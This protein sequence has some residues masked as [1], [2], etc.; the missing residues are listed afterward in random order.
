[1]KHLLF[2]LL[3]LSA[4]TPAAKTPHRNGRNPDRVKRN[5]NSP[6]Y[7]QN[8]TSVPPVVTNNSSSEGLKQ[9]LRGFVCRDFDRID[10]AGGADDA[11]M[12][13]T[14]G[15]IIQLYWKDIQPK[16]GGEITRN[17]RVDQAIE[18]ARKFKAKYGVDIPIKVRLYCG[19]YSPD[20][21]L[22]K[23]SFTIMEEQLPKYWEPYFMAAFAD[24]QQKLAAIYD[25]VP[26]I[27]EVVDGATGLKS[28][29]NF[30]RPFGDN[31][32]KQMAGQAFLQAGYTKAKDSIAI[33]RSYDAMK[34]WKHT[35]VS[36]C[37]SA[38][39][40]IDS[41][42][43]VYESGDGTIPF[44]NAFVNTFGKQ[45][46]IGNNGLRT[47]A[48]HNG[49]DFAEGGERFKIYTYFKKLHD[50]NGVKVYFQTSTTKRSGSELSPVIEDGIKYGASYIELPTSP[51]QYRE[52]LGNNLEAL[53]SRIKNN[54]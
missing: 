18:W 46:V 26:E 54:K 36:C 5:A 42:G 24:V 10:V 45:A 28:A 21:L 33:I 43:T 3:L 2:F 25:N 15:V 22:N 50:E 12:K 14:N 20:W 7:N 29:E 37:Y 17:N 31:G 48:G 40:Y 23:G 51:K 11:M 4:C 49:E 38:Y 30:I 39:Q 9:P 44:I 27:S 47:T 52:L 16:E 1:M 34:V 41:R 35:L 8:Q 19:V 6:V 13:I 32:K 53:N